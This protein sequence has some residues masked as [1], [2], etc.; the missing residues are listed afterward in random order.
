MQS[1]TFKTPF[2]RLALHFKPEKREHGM[3]DQVFITPARTLIF[4]NGT[5]ATSDPEIIE[6]VRKSV[7]FKSGEI[8]E[9]TDRDRAAVTTRPA[10]IRG[11]VS[12]EELGRPVIQQGLAIKERGGTNTCAVCHASFTDDLHGRKLRMHMMKHRREEQ[13][14]ASIQ[15]K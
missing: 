6:Y 5:L 2:V 9:I 10:G 4:E 15:E 13:K 1:V 12:S 8:T 3:G 11:V 14:A 7:A